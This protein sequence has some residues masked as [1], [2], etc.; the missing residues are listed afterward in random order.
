MRLLPYTRRHLLH[1]CWLNLRAFVVVL[2]L[3]QIGM[4]DGETI[5]CFMQQVGGSC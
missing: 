3:L 1:A 2:L 5:D 4:E